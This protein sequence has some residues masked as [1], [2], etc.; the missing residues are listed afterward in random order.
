MTVM[1]LRPPAKSTLRAPVKCPVRSASAARPVRLTRRGRLVVGGLAILTAVLAAVLLSVTASGGAL[2]A[3]HGSAGSGYQG[4]RQVVVQPGQTLWTLAAAAEPGGGG[5][6]GMPHTRSGN[7]QAPSPARS[8]SP[9]HDCRR[10][11]CVLGSGGPQYLV[12][13]AL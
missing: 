5:R 12:V 3:N 10:V 13:T 2:A 7:T 9:G 4:M 1:T 11:A 6:R 8:G